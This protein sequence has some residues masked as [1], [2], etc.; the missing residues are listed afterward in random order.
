MR[1]FTSLAIP[2]WASTVLGLLLILLGQSFAVS[3]MLIFSIMMNRSHLGFLPVRDYSYFVARE[4]TLM[5]A[6]VQTYRGNA[7]IE[8]QIIQK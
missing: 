4:T 8:S 7:A 2:G 5:P 1:L 6:I 3:F